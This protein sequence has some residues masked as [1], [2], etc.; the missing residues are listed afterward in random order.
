M[1]QNGGGGSPQQKKSKHSGGGVSSSICAAD[2]AAEPLLRYADAIKHVKGISFEVIQKPLDISVH[3]QEVKSFTQNAN[4]IISPFTQ[5]HQVAWEK[6]RQ[7]LKSMGVNITRSSSSIYSLFNPR[8]NMQS[9]NQ[10][11]ESVY[12]IVLHSYDHTKISKNSGLYLPYEIKGYSIP[13]DYEISG[14]AQ[15][16][17][18]IGI[19]TKETQPMRVLFHE[20]GH[21]LGLNHFPRGFA[22]KYPHCIDGFHEDNLPDD[23]RQDA[24]KLAKE[25]KCQIPW[26]DCKHSSVMYCQQPPS[27]PDSG[28]P[29]G[30]KL[31][32]LQRYELMTT[33]RPNNLCPTDIGQTP[34]PPI[35]YTPPTAEQFP[36]VPMMQAGFWLASKFGLCERVTGQVSVNFDPATEKLYQKQMRRS[37]VESMLKNQGT[38]LERSLPYLFGGQGNGYEMPEMEEFI[39]DVLSGNVNAGI[40]SKFFSLANIP[41]HHLRSEQMYKLFS[42]MHT[43][44]MLQKLGFC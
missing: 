35:Y 19:S 2:K 5:E 29:P 26:I 42:D 27:C 1:Y 31:A 21:V 4:G 3:Q 10:R 37:S 36:V 16:C 30:D 15:Y 11:V 12:K 39:I 44:R 9:S 25:M 38:S 34:Q 17:M 14:E 20:L 41:N 32:F 6:V 43:E 13:L 7:E 18:F 28:L 33:G 8:Q 22:S 23:K 24:L 40:R